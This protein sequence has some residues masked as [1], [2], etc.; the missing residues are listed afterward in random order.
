MKLRFILATIAVSMTTLAAA[1]A[2]PRIGY[3]DSQ[4]L[5][6]QL[7]EFKGIQQ[8][9]ENLRQ[10][11]QQEAIDRES[12]LRSMQEAFTKQE[13]LMS[14]ARKAQMQQ[15]MEAQYM[16][17]QQYTQEKLGPEGEL[18]RKHLELSS[19]I[20][21]HVNDVLKLIAAEDSY[22][23]IL[24]AA[25]GGVI[26]FA[27]PEYD[28]TDKLLARLLAEKESAQTETETEEEEAEAE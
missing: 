13:L 17:L 19:P 28:L 15:E 26:V 8:Q 11:F 22:D 18:A 4:V 27:D 16:Q 5:T 20:Y 1:S 9:L 12:K 3:I 6:Q 2:Q 25:V 14:E 21:K 10:S 24:D 7:P 23:L